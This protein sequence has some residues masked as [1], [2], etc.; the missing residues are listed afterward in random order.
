M[1][2][3]ICDMDGTLLDSNKRLP[4][5]LFAVIEELKKQNVCFGA[6]SGR[7]YFNLYQQFGEYAKDMLFIAENGGILYEGETPLFADKITPEELRPVIDQARACPN[8]YPILCGVNSAYLETQDDEFL[9]NA[10]MYYHRLKIVDDLMDVLSKDQIA[11]V[12]IFDKDNAETNSYPLISPHTGRLRAVVSGKEWIDVS[13]PDVSKGKAIKILKQKYQ[14][15]SDDFV[16][17]GD[18][19]NDYEMMKEC[20]YSYAMANAHPDLKKVCH[21]EA[22]SND[23]DGV[24]KAVCALF[25][26][27]Y[28][29]L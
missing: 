11:K 26:L 7:Q 14:L 27:D 13:N 1:K 12:A 15:S 8:A 29:A 23:E 24:M 10:H 2:Y 19:M 17:F 16:V 21:Y 22:L 9:K 5:K 18:F 25:D 28:E 20:T 3:V 6:A 4:N